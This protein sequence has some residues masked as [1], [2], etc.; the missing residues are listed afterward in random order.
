MT[1][2]NLLP[3]PGLE[4]PNVA[5]V[6]AD[7][8][9]MSTAESTGPPP[10]AT[11]LLAEDSKFLRLVNAQTLSRAGY[12]VLAAVDGEET[13]RITRE[14]HPDLIVLDML[15]PKL[16]GLEVLRILKQDPATC[17]IPIIVLSSLSKANEQKLKNDGVAEF[18]EKAALE[19][20]KGG[21]LVKAVERV[22]RADPESCDLIE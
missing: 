14:S 17:D 20:D 16:P 8:H 13:V 21:V 15:L 7:L 6:F 4:L 18:V 2:P 12:K 1:K 5:A 9:P 3:A 10:Q 11:V 19:N 22:L